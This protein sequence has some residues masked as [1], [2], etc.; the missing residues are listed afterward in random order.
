MTRFEAWL[1][2][3]SNLLVGG[4]G[5]VYA[6]MCYLATPSDPFAVVNHPWQPTLQHLHVLVAPLLVFAVGLTF[7]AH[8]WRHFRTG[9]RRCRGTGLVL[10]GMLVPMAV[11]GYLIQTTVGAGWRQT[12]VVVHVATS[13][14]WL[15][16][17]AG[18]LVTRARAR[19]SNGHEAPTQPEEIL[20]PS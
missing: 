7:K 11:S 10:L 15:A 19:E 18:H 9:V 12:W 6:W 20:N 5:L 16:A 2:H 3:G 8:A 14:A 13:L 4:T 17:Y 1:L